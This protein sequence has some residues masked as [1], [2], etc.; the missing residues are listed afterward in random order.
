MDEHTI[1]QDI[2]D[3]LTEEIP[4]DMNILPDIHKQLQQ[5]SRS[6]VRPMLTLSRVA[7]V[8]AIFVLVSAGGYALFQR[9]L[10]SKDIPQQ[11]ITDINETQTIEDV[12]VT[13]N[14]AYA[15]AHRLALAY[16][17]EFPRMDNFINSP[18]ITLETAD[19]L[20]LMPAFG[21]GG[22]GGGAP[23]TPV[24]S[25]TIMNFDTSTIEG[26]PDSIDLVLTLDFSAEAVQSNQFVPMSGGGGGG[27]NMPPV[28]GTAP[29][30]TPPVGGGG[31]GGG[32]SSSGGGGGGGG[33]MP[34]EYATPDVNQVIDRVY[35]FEFTLPF[36]E[37]LQVEPEENT[38]E[39]NGVTI[40]VDNIRYTPSLTKF[41]MCYNMPDDEQWGAQL[42]IITDSED[43][44][45]YS[46]QVIPTDATVE[47]RP[48]FEVSAAAAIP[49]DAEEFIID[50]LF[51][52]Q[53]I[54]PISSEA[55]R[56]EE[57]YFADLGYEIVID[58]DRYGYSMDI[59][60]YPE[61][62]SEDNAQGFVQTN[63]FFKRYEGDWKF[64][65]PLQ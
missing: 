14:W 55:A 7:A 25:E 53:P 31:G 41:D 11:R 8:I 5:S 28:S 1:Q 47:G 63:L 20:E 45:F 21:G 33:S 62:M 37:A 51:L 54:R 3:I 44:P 43:S 49:D 23:D 30:A 59:L 29:E 65:V 32:G 39:S 9:N 64:T 6:R 10:V 38:V 58:E 46:R 24:Y 50:V 34:P 12:E 15:D 27:G 13:L 26:S 22:G 56:A 42:Q 4:D 57:A 40:T 61:D 16:S 17:M 19:G 60:S 48:C 35:T 18:V 36:Y 2:H 52:A